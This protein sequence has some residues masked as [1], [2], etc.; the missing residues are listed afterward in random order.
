MKI[1]YLW[2]IMTGLEG[3][4][5]KD[6]C[7][8]GSRY[9][10]AGDH[11][12]MKLTHKSIEPTRFVELGLDVP[13]G[14]K[15]WAADFC[16]SIE[17]RHRERIPKSVLD[18]FARQINENGFSLNLF[19]S[20]NLCGHVLEKAT[21]TAQADGTYRLSG[22]LWVDDNAIMED[23]DKISVNRAIETRTIR[24][25]SVEISGPVEYIEAPEGARGFWQYYIDPMAPNRTEILGLALVRKGAQHAQGVK[26]KSANS[27]I[28]NK[29]K[30]NSFIMIDK[31]FEIGGKSFRLHTEKSGESVALKGHDELIAGFREAVKEKAE[32]E[33]RLKAATDETNAIRESLTTDI[34]NLS[35][36]LKQD[37]P[38]AEALATKSVADLYKSVTELRAK[39]DGGDTTTREKEVSTFKNVAY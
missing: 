4:I 28:V 11:F 33:A 19:H 2:A 14:G 22:Y 38:T 12:S 5:L 8:A 36:A 27:P 23:Q 13:D 24:E 20:N 21:V 30:S 25:L 26:V 31:E 29:E 1:S 10:V 35:G 7:F 34:I 3:L 32:S 18:Q 15:V 16:G 39:H 37:V 17:D 9:D 6:D